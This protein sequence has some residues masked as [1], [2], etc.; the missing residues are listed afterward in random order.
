MTVRVYL[1]TLHADRETFV[2][3]VFAHRAAAVRWAKR[4]QERA[5]GSSWAR[6]YSYSVDEYLVETEVS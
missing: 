2:V 3:R 4:L 5:D 1:L 6:A